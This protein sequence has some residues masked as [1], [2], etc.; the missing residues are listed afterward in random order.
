[1]IADIVPGE[2]FRLGWFTPDMVQVLCGA[3]VTVPELFEPLCEGMHAFV[4]ADTLEVKNNGPKRARILITGRGPGNAHRTVDVRYEPAPYGVQT[5]QDR[6]MI[7]LVCQGEGSL[8]TADGQ[9]IQ[10]RPWLSWGWF[11]RGERYSFTGRLKLASIHAHVQPG[12]PK[13]TTSGRGLMKALLS[14]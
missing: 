10:I 1:M 9:E 5:C 6:Y 7:W 8:T 13:P 14:T 11:N 2:T 4:R 12:A 3:N